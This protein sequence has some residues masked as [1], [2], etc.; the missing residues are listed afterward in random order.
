MPIYEV[1]GWINCI[2]CGREGGREVLNKCEK[3]TERER[4]KIIR[5]KK[6]I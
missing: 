5:K 2:W 1:E 6:K 4:K 3:K